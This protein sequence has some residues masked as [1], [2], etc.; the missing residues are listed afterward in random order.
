VFIRLWWFFLWHRY[1]V[2]HTSNSKA[3]LLVSIAAKLAGHPNHVATVH[4]RDYENDS[5]LKKTGFVCV[6]QNC[7][8][9]VGQN[10]CCFT[11]NARRH[12][13]RRNRKS[14]LPSIVREGQLLRF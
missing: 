5:G 8:L 2:I 14:I 9:A 10:H 1:D 6:G 13:A 11:I 3:I 4:G 7:L 12:G